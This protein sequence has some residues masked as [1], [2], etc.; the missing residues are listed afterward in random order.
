[1]SMPDGNMM[2][3]PFSHM[4]YER[5]RREEQLKDLTKEERIL[6]KELCSFFDSTAIRGEWGRKLHVPRKQLNSLS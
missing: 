6:L 2:M 4:M 1:M 3:A 5:N